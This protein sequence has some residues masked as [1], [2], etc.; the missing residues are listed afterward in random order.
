ML[1]NAHLCK[2][3]WLCSINGHY[4]FEVKVQDHIKLKIIWALFVQSLWNDSYLCLDRRHQPKTKAHIFHIQHSGIVTLANF[5]ACVF[6]FQSSK[7]HEDIFIPTASAIPS[8]NADEWISGQNR[9][10]ILISMQ[11]DLVPSFHLL[12]YISLITPCF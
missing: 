10:P 4:W 3:D 12:V 2:E 5:C 6:P 1:L 9:D 7:F 11:V 8:L